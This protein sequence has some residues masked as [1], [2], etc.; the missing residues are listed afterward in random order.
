MAHSEGSGAGKDRH[1]STEEGE[2]DEV[3]REDV[4][5]GLLLPESCLGDFT[6]VGSR[7]RFNSSWRCGFREQCCS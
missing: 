3:W 1:D 2:M 7:I 6:R 5:Y 4:I